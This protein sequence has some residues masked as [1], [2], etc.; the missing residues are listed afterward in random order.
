LNIATTLADAEKLATLMF[1][2]SP[3][4]Y[5]ALDPREFGYAV[6]PPPRD[7]GVCWT[8]A[9]FVAVTAAEV[10]G[11]PRCFVPAGQAHCQQLR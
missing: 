9:A 2:T 6:V 1:A 10:W 3:A 5:S 8:V 4:A 7:E 11:Q